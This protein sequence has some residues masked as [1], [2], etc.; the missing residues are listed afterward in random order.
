MKTRK[1]I[2]NRSYFEILGIAFISWYAGHLLLAL[3]TLIPL[4]LMGMEERHLEFVDL[5]VWSVILIFLIRK[6]I[7]MKEA[8]RRSRGKYFLYF[9]FWMLFFLVFIVL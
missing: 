1:N 5:L 2:E 4:G 8:I 6:D 9:I 3:M 7:F